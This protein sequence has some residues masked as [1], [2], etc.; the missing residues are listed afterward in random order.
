MLVEVTILVAML[1][2]YPVSKLLILGILAK[3][4]WVRED[5][6]KSLRQCG[7]DIPAPDQAASLLNGLRP[8]ILMVSLY[9]IYLTVAFFILALHGE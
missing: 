8:L 1:A 6:P 4:E 2:L 3:P 5:W 9:S 7:L